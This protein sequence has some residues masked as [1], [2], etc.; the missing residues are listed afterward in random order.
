MKIKIEDSYTQFSYEGLLTYLDGT[1]KW[2]EI[3]QWA[4]AK[5]K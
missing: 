3:Q 1:Y 2:F 5:N 4:V